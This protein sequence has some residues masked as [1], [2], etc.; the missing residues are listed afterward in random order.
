MIHLSLMVTT[1]PSRAAQLERLVSMLGLSD[2]EFAEG[3]F[4]KGTI[5]AWID[6][7]MGVEL[8]AYSTPPYEDSSPDPDLTFGAKRNSI[9]K[10][11]QGEYVTSFDDD[12][13]P[14]PEYLE[15]I[16]K[17]IDQKPDVIGY[18]VACYGYAQ[19]NGQFDPSIM[20]PAD[21]STKYDGW[22]NDRNGFKYVRCPHHIVPV[23]KEHVM[24]IGFKPMHHGEDHE[25][26][27]RLR[28]SGRL[29][30]EVYIDEF[31]YIY[32]FNAKKQKGE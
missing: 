31:L 6:H 9:L 24:A 16:L 8:L 23:R 14:H 25:Y 17:A 32:R 13:E 11:A 4:V 1:M 19:T 29:K 15:R 30:K 3:P 10:V 20:E 28:D 18:K 5:R 7:Q 2:A 21:V 27:M 12:D 22:Y 26:S